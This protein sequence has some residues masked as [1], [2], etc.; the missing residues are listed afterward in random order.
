M[1]FHRILI[2]LLVLASLAGC[3]NRKAEPIARDTPAAPEEYR[4]GVGDI[5]SIRVYGG[6]EDLTFPRIRLN[7]RGALTLPF[8]DFTA[9]GQTTRQLEAK[10]TAGVKGQ[11]LLNPRVWVNIEE[12]RPF[13]VQG[14]VARPG[15]FPYQPGM[16]VLRAITIAGGLRERASKSNWFVIRENDKSNRQVR[17][18]QNS[19]VGPGD[20]IIVEES[21]F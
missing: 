21:F 4:L 2:S 15:L 6:E 13:Y 20:T 14:Q 1:V 12:Y 7:D 10:I 8:G 16:T 3:F 9:Y 11:Y 18:D 5:I 19:T 17:V